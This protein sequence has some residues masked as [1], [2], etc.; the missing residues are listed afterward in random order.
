MTL[1]LARS[2]KAE[3]KTHTG[4]RAVHLS[5]TPDEY[6]FVEIDLDDFCVMARYVLT[7]TDLMP[8][9]PRL[10]LLKQVKRMRTVKGYNYNA[11]KKARRLEVT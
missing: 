7:N 2:K 4:E 10:E 9:D 1:I 11:D 5:L 3:V 6:G 8:D